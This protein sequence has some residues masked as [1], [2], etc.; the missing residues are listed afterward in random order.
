MRSASIRDSPHPC[1]A[2]G[3]G[4]GTTRRCNSQGRI[5]VS[6][7]RC[8]RRMRGRMHSNCA[9]CT[10]RNPQRAPA[11]R[12]TRKRIRSRMIAIGTRA[13]PRADVRHRLVGP[14]RIGSGT[15]RRRP[16]RR[17]G[18][19]APLRRRGRSCKPRGPRSS[20][21]RRIRCMRAIPSSDRR[22]AQPCDR[23][24]PQSAGSSSPPTPPSAQRR[25]RSWQRV[26]ARFE[27]T[28]NRHDLSSHLAGACDYP[29]EAKR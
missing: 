14:A 16:R 5:S 7:T 13:R 6:R 22:Q 15:S 8:S 18:T 9:R 24:C 17:R 21:L 20:A 2:R 1:P 12:R 25:R 27:Q 28:T 29:R 26:V 11:L 19:R 3:R 10:R 4:A 23:R